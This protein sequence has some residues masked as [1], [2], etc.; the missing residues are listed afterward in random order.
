[1]IN[2]YFLSG[3]CVNC[4]VFDKIKL[5]IGYEKQY[6]EWHIPRDDETLEEY[7]RTMA[8]NIDTTHPF[9]LVGYSL[10]GIIMQEMNK[11]LK[12]E[13]NILISSMKNKS[14]IP[15][16]FRIAK[17]TH[18]T[19]LLPK[20]LYTTNKS[21]SN[22]FTHLVYDMSIDDI[23]QCVTYTSAE[24]MK[25]ASYQ[26]THWEPTIEIENLYHIHGIKDQ[27]FPYKQIQNA[28]YVEDGDH[29]MVMKKAEK[30]N[31]ILNDM[32]LK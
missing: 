17:M 18:I 16:L 31:Q 29:L 1:M 19:K 4:K 28:F 15:P 11:F 3:M 5:P 6:I 7:T 21:I 25:W 12:P 30:V 24:Y 27:V 23:E 13:K 32:I 20:Q 9:I 8:N 26:I 10:G 2:V 22:L 14:E